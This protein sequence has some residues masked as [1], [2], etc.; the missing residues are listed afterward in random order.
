MG[1]R[2]YLL[3]LLFFLSGVSGLVYQVVWVRLFGN[4]FGNTVYS[5]AMVVAVFMLGLGAGGY[6]FGAW[7]DRRYAARPESLLRAYGSVEIAIGACGL[8]IA[9][10]APHLV[11]IVAAVSS[12]V[13]GEHGWWVLS[14]PSYLSRAATAI[15]LLTPAT[16]LMGGTLS[17]LV[18]H[19][20]RADVVETGGRRIALLYGVNTLGAA[21][22]ALL[23]DF[24]LVPAYG[25]RATQLIAVALNLGAGAGALWLASRGAAP[26]RVPSKR[27]VAVDTAA[28]T[29][30]G[31]LLVVVVGLVLALSGLA[32]MGMEIVWFRHFTMMLG[33][34][35]AVFSL[36]LAIV[37][38]GIGVGALLAG[39][40]VRRRAEAAA[41]W[42]MAV[43][44]SFVAA[45][46]LGLYVADSSAL[47]A[48][49]RAAPA[50]RAGLGQAGPAVQQP[51]AL[52]ELWFNA[53]PMLIE[54]AL[55][56]L[57]MGFSFPLGNALVQRA[58]PAVG[59]RC[60][61][62]YLANTLGAV[63]GSLATGFVLMPR[64]GL[65]TTATVLM[66]ASAAT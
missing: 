64:L 9:W 54:V 46:L 65:Q 20:V 57:L 19:L 52:V 1:A 62:L 43:Q 39:A 2:L 6:G 11:Q 44:A 3:F 31:P 32:A 60:G 14:A 56:A 17:L 34:F 16:L 27:R 47:D 30:G 40:L 28:A 21:A 55:P 41:G 29:A 18:R 5:A 24:A 26:P 66:L 58:E 42:F 48:M 63:A 61:A 37:L 36:L 22:G 7:A 15:L 35:R 49:L 4:V 45:V 50:V 8:L 23:T 59:R 38:V 13:P 12:Y 51:G 33:Q 25:L 10:I 53:R